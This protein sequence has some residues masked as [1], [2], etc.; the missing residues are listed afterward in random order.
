MT[1]FNWGFRANKKLYQ[2]EQ[3]I[4]LAL[5]NGDSTKLKDLI[6]SLPSLKNEKLILHPLLF[7]GA[8]QSMYYGSANSEDKFRVFYGR[9]VFNYKDGGICSLD[10]VKDPESKEVFDAKYKETLLENWPKLLPRT[11]FFDKSELEALQKVD[12]ESIKPIVVIFHGIGGSSHELLVRNFA[13]LLTTG[14]NTGK[15]DVVI[16]CSRGCG[17]TKVTSGKLFNALAMDDLHEIIVALKSRGPNRPLYTVGFSFGAVML[18]NYLGFRKEET[19]KLIK[20]AA[21]VGCPFNL[22]KS[23]KGLRDSWSGAYMFNPAVAGYLNKMVK[24]NYN[25][26]HE[27]V[28]ELVNKELLEKTAKAKDTFTF[29]DHITCKTAGFDNATDYYAKSAPELRLKDINVPYLS[30]SSS[31]DPT[32]A[33]YIPN[34]KFIANPYTAS[35]ET[36]LGGHLAFVTPSK[37]FWCVKVI[38]EFF[39]ALENVDA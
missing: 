15:F 5:K 33:S 31:D 4:D 12:S 35:V 18:T 6:K 7:N 36:D 8:L 20:G 39:E 17:R 22:N 19:S 32:N 1:I 16:A 11:R 37:Q 34:D 10:W 29:D 23:V 2:S 25:E 14:K 28:P 21:V 27:F 24:N 38:D 3:S 9:E 30:I 13:Q 26:L